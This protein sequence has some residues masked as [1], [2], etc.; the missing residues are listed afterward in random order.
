MQSQETALHVLRYFLNI[1]TIIYLLCFIFIFFCF[2]YYFFIDCRQFL[3]DMYFVLAL[4][5]Q[6]KSVCVERVPSLQSDL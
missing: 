5:L 1:Y 6:I 3:L 4:I 2:Y